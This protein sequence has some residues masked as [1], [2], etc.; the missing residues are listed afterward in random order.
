LC[1]NQ[2]LR[3]KLSSKGR[4]VVEKDFNCSRYVQTL[5]ALYETAVKQSVRG[6]KG[7]TLTLNSPD[8]GFSA[9]PSVPTNG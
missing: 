9:T 7:P 3:Q 4:A 5:T 1:L 6:S 8:A 2:E